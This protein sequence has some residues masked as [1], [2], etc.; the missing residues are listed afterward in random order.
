MKEGEERMGT[1]IMALIYDGGVLLGA[2][3]RTT[4]GS[5]IPFRTSD[6]IDFVFDKVFLLRS[7]SAADTQTLCKY[8]RYNTNIHALELNRPPALKTV[9]RLFSSMIY[10][11]KD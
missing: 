2:D 4:S 3:S 11:Y 9:A 10:Q 8:V 7:G 1:T 5:Y 6:K